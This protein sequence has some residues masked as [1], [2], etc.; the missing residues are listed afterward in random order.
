MAL[1]KIQRLKV[2]QTISPS[3]V[4]VISI[5]AQAAIRFYHA[6]SLDRLL[7][8]SSCRLRPVQSSW[9]SIPM[10]AVPNTILTYCHLSQ[11]RH[12]YRITP[13]PDRHERCTSCAPRVMWVAL[14]SYCTTQMISQRT[15]KLSY[16][17]KILC[18]TCR[19]DS[20]LQSRRPKRKSYGCFFGCHPHYRQTLSPFL[21]A[22]LPS[23]LVLVA[24]V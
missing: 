12:I 6:T 7:P 23:H 15:C 19:A 13:K 5:D 4:D 22:R 3:H 2:S 11:K 9:R 18:Q 20:I 1:H 16:C 21:R 10:R 14:S 8:T 17:I 24:K